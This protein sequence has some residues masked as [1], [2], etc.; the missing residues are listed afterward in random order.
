M[1]YAGDLFLDFL[2][3]LAIFILEWLGYGVY[4]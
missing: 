3:S 1:Y 4:W 2:F